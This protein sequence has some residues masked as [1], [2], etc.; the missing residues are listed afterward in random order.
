MTFNDLGFGAKLSVWALRQWA[1]AACTRGNCLPMLTHVFAKA[2]IAPAA[3]HLDT[4]LRTVEARGRRPVAIHPPCVACL[5][6][7]EC[8]WLA[9]IED[10]QTGVLRVAPA[11]ASWRAVVRDG[12]AARRIL[13][14]WLPETAARGA[15]LAAARYAQQLLTAHLYVQA[16]PVPATTAGEDAPDRGDNPSPGGEGPRRNRVH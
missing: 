9:C 12:S 7:D 1:L 6:R 8:L 10:L 16:P 13:Y 3:A 11:E 4:V 2:G 14:D 5:A 15:G